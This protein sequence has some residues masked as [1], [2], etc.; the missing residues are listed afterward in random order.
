MWAW[1]EEFVDFVAGQIHK[2]IP[3]ADEASVHD[4]AVGITGIYFNADSLKPLGAS[5]A[6]AETSRRAAR[7][8]LSSLV[9][10]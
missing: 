7:R 2:Q 9:A 3:T 1:F 6:V 5:E 4:V 10:G 8:L